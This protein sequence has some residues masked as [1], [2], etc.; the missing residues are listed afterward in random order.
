MPRSAHIARSLAAALATALLA[1]CPQ[2]PPPPPPP[3]SHQ[4]WIH[5]DSGLSPSEL[6]ILYHE[7]E[8]SEF[9]PLA[10]LSALHTPEGQTLLSSPQSYG[11]LEDPADPDHLP[12]GMSKHRFPGVISD[13]V[14]FNCAACHVN[15][16]HYQGTSVR[17]DGAPGLFNLNAFYAGLFHSILNTLMKPEELEGFLI[18]FADQQGHREPGE[19]DAHLLRRFYDE[20]GLPQDDAGLQAYVQAQTEHYAEIEQQGGLQLPAPATLL[21]KSADDVD[22]FKETV[23]F[24]EGHLTYLSPLTKLNSPTAAG[25]GR[26]DAFNGARA[27]LFGLKQAI[28]LSA[29][30]SYPFLWGFSEQSWLHYDGNTNSVMQRNMGQAMGLGATYDPQKGSSTLLPKEIDTLDKL[31]AQ[32]K[33]PRW[34][35]D[36]FG[37]IDP[38]RSEAGR[39]VF[40]ENCAECHVPGS[41]KTMLYSLDVIGTDPNRATTFDSKVQPDPSSPEV[42]YS[43]ALASVLA[44]LEDKAFEDAGLSPEERQAM[45]PASPVWR[46]TNKYAA[47]PLNSIWATAPY[48]HNGSVPTLWDLLQPAGQRPTCFQ[49]GQRDYD[50]DTLGYSTSADSAGKCSSEQK[51][52]ETPPSEGFV[53]WFNVQCTGNSNAG[54]EYGTHL[55]EEQKRQLLEYLKTL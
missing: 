39:Q 20:E 45:E 31:A 27:L 48:L 49:V 21:L 17:V 12:V 29:P 23:A 18:R 30:V 52:C 24:L 37:K 47:R 16:F 35:E 36:V 41:G 1:G 38:A 6:A 34:P 7:P 22:T 2:S 42:P 25:P 28:P 15:E 51:A 53:Q 5:I 26:L 55:P 14:G 3:P 44:K 33:A 9:L 11:L 40:Q 13:S 54:H 8:G 50:P 4:P 43:Q 10:V 32:V 19:S 46:T